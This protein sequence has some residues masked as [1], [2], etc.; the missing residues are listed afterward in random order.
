[1]DTACNTAGAG[2]KHVKP[3]VLVHQN[4]RGLTGKLDEVIILTLSIFFS[5]ALI[6]RGMIKIHKPNQPIRPIVNWTNA[7]AYK[8]ARLFNSKLHE[9]APLPY[10][11]N[12]KNTTQ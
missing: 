10:V 9:L 3:L 11:Y 2:M 5:T 12:I 7:L 1:M 8:L 6:I 4:I